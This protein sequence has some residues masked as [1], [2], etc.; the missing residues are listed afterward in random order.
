MILIKVHELIIIVEL[1]EEETNKSIT[2][3]LIRKEEKRK[4]NKSGKRGKV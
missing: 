4:K 2:K 3:Y 1:N